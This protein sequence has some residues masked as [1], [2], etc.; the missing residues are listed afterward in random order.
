M[1]S[2]YLVCILVVLV[3]IF[4]LLICSCS[5]SPPRLQ[6]RRV[7][8]VPPVEIKENYREYASLDPKNLT[9]P[10]LQMNKE[11]F[12]NEY[13]LD[14]KPMESSSPYYRHLFVHPQTDSSKPIA[15]DTMIPKVVPPQEVVPQVVVP[16]VVVPQVVVPQNQEVVPK[17]E[18]FIYEYRTDIKPLSSSS[19]YYGQII[20]NPEVELQY[21]PEK[22]IRNNTQI[23]TKLLSSSSPFYGQL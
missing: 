18:S 1:K 5:P 11:G 3:I 15:V 9:S 20:E 10:N 12:I 4:L 17:K 14:M 16:Q 6:R 21:K 22:Q 23:P 7:L 8:I 2:K 13:R 19:P